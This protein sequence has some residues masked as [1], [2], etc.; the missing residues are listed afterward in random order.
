[1]ATN[2]ELI[3][4]C[5]RNNISFRVCTISF[6][7]SILAIVNYSRVCD[8]LVVNLEGKGSILLDK[9]WNGK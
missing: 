3:C 7:T 5:N 9:V 4:H 6:S 1:M 2:R 8:I